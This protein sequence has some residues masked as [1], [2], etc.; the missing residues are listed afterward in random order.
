MKKTIVI[1]ILAVY[2]A[3]IAVVNFFGLE[4]KIFD[5][6]TYV[7]GI[8]CDSVI[9]RGN[10]TNDVL[11]PVHYKGDTPQFVFNFIP[12]DPGT[13]YTADEE[14]LR[15]NPNVIEINFSTFPYNADDTSVQYEYDEAAMN[16]IAVFREDLRI[17]IFL[18]PNKTF[19]MTIR[20]MVTEGEVKTSV[21]IIGN[22]KV[23]DKNS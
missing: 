21:S 16:G 15:T 23:E 4:V 9:F 3:S 5:G 18:K 13:E 22:Y 1:V 6:I 20:P 10:G 12:P 19:N 17:L 7:N 14:S 2:I 11:Q 8:Q